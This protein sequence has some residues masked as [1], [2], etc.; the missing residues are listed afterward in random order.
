MAQQNNRNNRD[1]GNKP[2]DTRNKY[3]RFKKNGINT[4]ITKTRTSC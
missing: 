1:N 3:C 2:V 4:W